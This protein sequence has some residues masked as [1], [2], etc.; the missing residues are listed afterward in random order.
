MIILGD[1]WAGRDGAREPNSSNLAREFPWQ[2][3][4]ERS[5]EEAGANRRGR[6]VLELGVALVSV[7]RRESSEQGAERSGFG[8]RQVAWP[9]QFRRVV[10]AVEHSDADLEK[11]KNSYFV[12]FSIFAKIHEG[13]KNHIM[14]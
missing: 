13:S 2:N 1:N 11:R 4:E 10:V 5:A 6:R 8:E 12:K 3:A 7:A 9:E 14:K